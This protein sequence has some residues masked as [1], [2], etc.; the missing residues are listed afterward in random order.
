MD[1]ETI[2]KIFA[3]HFGKPTITVHAP[4]RINLIG[5]HLDYNHGLVLPAAID[6]RLYFA[7]SKN[8]K[9]PQEVIIYSADYDQLSSFSLADG[10]QQEI[11]GWLRYLE[12]I[13]LV[14]KEKGYSLKGY[15]CAFGGDIPIGAGLSSSAALTCGLIRGLSELFQWNLPKEEIALIAQAAEH[16]VGILCGLMDQYAVLFG[17]KGKVIQLDCRDLKVAY[18]PCELGNHCL[19]LF[20]TKVE[21]SLAATAYNDRRASCERILQQIQEK[22]ANEKIETLRD[23]QPSM[24]K[25]NSALDA[26]DVQR[27]QFVLAENERVVQTTKALQAGKLKEVGQLLYQSHEGLSKGYEVSCEELDILVDL[28]RKEKDILGARMMG[29]GFGGCTINLVKTAVAKKVQAKILAAYREKT[30]IQGEA[31]VVNIGDGV[32]V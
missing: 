32:G 13:A 7:L 11:A 8:E 1:R 23:V 19:L 12:A 18:F 22:H 5:E 20:N 14:L 3:T 15:Q 28:A 26:L 17:Q 10:A 31:Y 16:R 29:G 21:H 27:V 9:Q 25:N 30:G 24:L 2:N 6:S 4:G